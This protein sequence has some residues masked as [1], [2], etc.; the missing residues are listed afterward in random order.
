M[1]PI[2]VGQAAPPVPGVAFDDGPVG[3]FF[4]KVTCPTCQ[5][6]APTMSGF[7]R[8]YP[9]RV[10]GVGQD[11]QDVLEAFGEVHGMGIRSLEDRPPYD[12]SNA[13]GI[14]SVPTLVVVGEDGVVLH[15]VGAWDR[16]GFNRA[17]EL[18]ASALGVR[19]V[20]ISAEGDG[21]PDFKPG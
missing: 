19:P 21:R 3:L 5:L 17:S 4:Y 15:T 18:I 6:A 16:E 12:V 20:T 1:A 13:Y 10:V 7:E 9:G 14:V 11:P 2:H 8:A